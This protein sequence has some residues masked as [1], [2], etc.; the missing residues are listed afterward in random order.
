MKIVRMFSIAMA[1]IMLV[2]TIVPF[3]VTPAAAQEST[4]L[5]TSSPAQAFVNAAQGLPLLAPMSISAPVISLNVEQVTSG[6][7]GCTL[8]KQTPTDWVKMRRRQSF[9]VYWTVQNTGGAV[10]HANA[11]KFAY[12]GG[13]KMQTREDAFRI[14]NDVGRGKK[15]KLGVDMVAPKTLGTY[16]TLW[17]LYSGKTSF[18]RVTLTVT[19]TR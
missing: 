14:N 15:I 17:A 9:D 6:S 13:T 12:V 3:A 19:V 2:A 16:S 7:Y 1:V 11:T 4:R 10:W 18:C 5:S 8:V